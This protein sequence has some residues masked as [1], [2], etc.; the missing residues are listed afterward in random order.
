MEN[1]F[2]NWG[3]PA[4]VISLLITLISITFYLSK[5]I[6]KRLKEQS[7]ALQEIKEEIKLYSE[8]ATTQG[9]RIEVFML[10]NTLFTVGRQNELRST[11]DSGLTFLISIP[12]VSISIYVLLTSE[13]HSLYTPMLWVINVLMLLSILMLAKNISYM[14]KIND[15]AQS[16]YIVAL[17]S[18]VDKHAR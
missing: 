6:K 5:N 15:V 4:S 3:N 14:R 17:E 9:K 10:L 2:N 18:V 12:A 13:W 1:F 7:N 8:T 11:I 16:E